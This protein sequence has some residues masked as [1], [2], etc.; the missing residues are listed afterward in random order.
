MVDLGSGFSYSN[1]GIFPGGVG[2][3]NTYNYCDGTPL[4]G[5]SGLSS[6]CAISVTFTPTASNSISAS[7]LTVNLTGA[8]TPS[9]SL[10]LIATSTAR[11]F[12]TVNENTGY[13]SC[14]NNCSPYYVGSIANSTT[15]GPLTLY[16]TNAGEFP[17]TLS[18]GGISNSPIFQYAGAGI[19]PGGG[20]CSTGLILTPG[21]SCTITLNFT[22][23]TAA[24]YNGTISVNGTDFMG[25]VSGSRN[26]SGQGI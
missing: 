24:F 8:T 17:A 12:L 11:A 5:P 4:S 9:V 16:V 14:E 10:P 13:F 23:A 6:Y 25:M 18:D 19:F 26:L 7:S 15:L 3:V 20:T 22:P 2:I 1:G 21:N